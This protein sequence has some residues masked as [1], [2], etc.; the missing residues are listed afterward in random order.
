MSEEELVGMYSLADLFVF[1]SLYE[2]FGLP[3]LEA[4]ACG[5]SVLTSNVTS[6]PEIAGEGAYM[7][8]PY[9]ERKIKKGIL[10]IL[11]NKK[12]RKEL[13]EKGFINAKKYSWKKTTKEILELCK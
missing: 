3:I 4:Q 13:V 8:D 9:S 12:Y 7:I 11:S 6:C 2:G 1:P 5:C 10:K